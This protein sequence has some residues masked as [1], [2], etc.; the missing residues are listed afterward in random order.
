MEVSQ[1]Q[2]EYSLCVSHH[3]S[4]GCDNDEDYDNHPDGYEHTHNDNPSSSSQIFK[5][6]GHGPSLREARRSRSFACLIEAG[7]A[8]PPDVKRIDPG[9]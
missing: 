3:K 4:K 8:R 1:S 2:S 9:R 6:I 7:R 5:H